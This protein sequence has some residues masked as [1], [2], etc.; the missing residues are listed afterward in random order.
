MDLKWDTFSSNQLST[1][2]LV[3]HTSILIKS[4]FAII[5]C[6]E[7][8]FED[9]SS[10]QTEPLIQ[11][12]NSLYPSYGALLVS[13]LKFI[14]VRTLGSSSLFLRKFWLL[15]I[16]FLSI[17]LWNLVFIADS[18]TLPPPVDEIVASI[19]HRELNST[20]NCFVCIGH[21]ARKLYFIY[22]VMNVHIATAPDSA[23]AANTFLSVWYIQRKPILS[24]IK[25]FSPAKLE[26]RYSSSSSQYKFG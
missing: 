5:V 24:A 20:K 8:S 3:S 19:F 23:L 16:Q 21:T 6:I 7:F 9:T 1:I 25:A 12:C 17:A 10:T 2:A 22:F 4:A 18:Q 14:S 11:W 26:Y 15:A 13:A